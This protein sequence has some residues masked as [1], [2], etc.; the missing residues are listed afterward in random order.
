MISRTLSRW[1]HPSPW[2]RSATALI[3]C[4][5][6]AAGPGC[7]GQRSSQRM[8]VILAQGP[9][10]PPGTVLFVLTAADVQTLANGKTRSTGYFLN[11]F[12]DAYDAVTLAGYQVEIATPD[13][14]PAVVDPESFDED[15][16]KDQPEVLAQARDLVQALPALQHPLTLDQAH[17]RVDE[18]QGL[19]VPGGQGV[20]VDLLEHPVLHE[21]LVALGRTD[22]PVGLVCHAPAVL[23][24]LPA[25]DDPFAGRWVTSVSAM[26]EWYIETFVMRGKALDRGIGE[27]L[28]D[29]GYRYDA[30]PPGKPHAV[31]DCNLVT[32]QNPFSGQPFAQELLAA[33][34]DWRHGGRCV[35]ASRGG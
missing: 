16:W 34:D 11:E 20:M 31:R 13:G 28:A 30:A 15:Y 14:R 12:Y 27:Q 18:L 35:E 1:P 29:R 6:L 22:R 10:R 24:R 9:A 7:G 25:H 8:S 19:V 2:T 21:L 26:E 5:L 17:Q 4:L 32:S 3:A 33:L 23:A